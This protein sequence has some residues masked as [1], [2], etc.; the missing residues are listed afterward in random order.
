M[1]V[2][3]DLAC[4]KEKVAIWQQQFWATSVYMPV[5]V[6]ATRSDLKFIAVTPC[7][8]FCAASHALIS[9][10]QNTAVSECS[11]K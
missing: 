2:V 11:Q 9:H 3:T 5:G 1:S 8:C 6:W 7:C 10:T 4:A